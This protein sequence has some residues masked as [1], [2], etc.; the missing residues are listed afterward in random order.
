[1]VLNEIFNVMVNDVTFRIKMMEFTHGPLRIMTENSL[2]K[3]ISS[4]ESESEVS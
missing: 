4:L 3:K 2:Q 1:M